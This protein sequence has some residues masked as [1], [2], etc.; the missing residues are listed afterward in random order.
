MKGFGAMISFYINGNI[1]DVNIFIKKLKNIP[2]AESLGGIET[3]ICH[4]A[5]MTHASVDIKEKII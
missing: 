5:S 4:P 1:N 3:L 2:L